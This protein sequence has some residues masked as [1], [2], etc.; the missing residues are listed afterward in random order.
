METSDIPSGWKR[1][2][3]KYSQNTSCIEKISQK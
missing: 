3:D 1:F 2:F